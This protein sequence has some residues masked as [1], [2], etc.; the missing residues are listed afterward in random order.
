MFMAARFRST[1]VALVAM[2]AVLFL[3][4]PV[5]HAADRTPED[6]APGTVVG[7]SPLPRDSW[8][9]G[10]ER[11]H[12]LTYRTTGPTGEPALSTGAVF[13]PP[14]T[15]PPGGWPVI[16]WAH[17]TVGIADHCAPTR[18]GLIGGSYVTH[19][20]SQGYA[21]VATDYV[22]LGTP[23]IHPYLDGAS[24]A[25]AVIDMVRAARAVEPGLSSRWAVIG[26]SQG[27]HAA[28]RTAAIA[29]EYAPELDFRGA[30]ATGAPSNIEN[31]AFL[32]G[33]DFPELPLEGSTVFIAYMLAGLRASRP[34][35]DIDSYL[36]TQGRQALQIAEQYCYADAAERLAGVTIGDL[37]SKSLNDPVFREA[38]RS[39]LHV[40]NSGYDR[41][42]FIGHGLAD[43][44][45]PVPF[46]FA[47]VSQL[48]ANGEHFDFRTYPTGHL[49]TMPASLGDTTPFVARILTR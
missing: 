17:G 35:V 39:A 27:G 12:L 6:A 18:T 25:H 1:L 29:T 22:G 21:L 23:G 11:A 16:S 34:H 24:E 33:P 4:T 46:T 8:L 31:L 14:G 43:V 7:V 13:V 45:V 41:P 38:A 49:Q 42:L 37:L 28:L 36:S 32:G 26:Q 30:V 9:D 47:L 19:W 48:R 15:P 5:V 44:M 10:T 40:P 2:V 3:A 20:F